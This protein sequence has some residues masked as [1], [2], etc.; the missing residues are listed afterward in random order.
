MTLLRGWFGVALWQRVMA[1]LAL[2]VAL[3]LA[4]PAAVPWVS[5]LGEIF[6]RL[7]RMLVVPIVLVT[8]AAGIASLSDFRRLGSIGGRAVLLFLATTVIAVSV[9]IAVGLIFQP[10]ADV[11]LASASP[12]ALGP[13]KTAHDTMMGI[14]PLN[15]FD[16]LGKGDMLAIL[17]VAVLLGAGTV[18]AGEAGAP[19]AALLESASN[20]LL[21]IVRFAME[22]T[23]FGVFALVAAAV[24]ANGVAIFASIG[25]LA[26]C[27]VI[28]SLVQ[29]LLV[30]SLLVRLVAHIPVSLFFRGIA[31][32][33]I[34]AFSTASSSATLP[35]AMRVAQDNLGIARPVAS[36]VLPLG[37]SI[38]KDGTAMY[39]GL[40]SMF[41]LQLFGVPIDPA[42]LGIVL[43]TAVLAALGTAPIPS[44][45]L[46]ML[47]AVLGA[48]GVTAEQTALVVGF[49]LPFDRLLDMT[50]TVPSASANLTVTAV[51]AALEGK[52]ALMTEAIP[53]SEP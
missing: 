24:A 42:T 38:G 36:M 32:A 44:A 26:L 9:G 30:H 5:F 16:A 4:A 28:G 45:S 51:V 50:R 39:V 17:F 23:P 29:M 6:V 27:V 12:H 11:S 10:G 52:R 40:L 43:L 53:S 2:G 19:L 14:V 21:H 20:V 8:V 15:I 22:F 13:A 34:V 49:I 25:I 7:I 46:F 47:A 1:G 33:L 48:A 18:A 37:A 41:G 31:D 35:V 3:G